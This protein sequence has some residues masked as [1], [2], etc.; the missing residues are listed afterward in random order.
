[1]TAPVAVRPSTPFVTETAIGESTPNLRRVWTEYRERDT[2]L[3]RGMDVRELLSR[4]NTASDEAREPNWNGEDG[5]PVEPSTIDQAWLFAA[6]LPTTLPIPD[7]SPDADGDL[8]FDWN[9]G[10]RRVFSVSVRRD[11]SLSYAALVGASRSHGTG[12]LRGGLP[13]EIIQW[14]QRVVGP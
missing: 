4:I 1:M 5:H 10:P 8:A 12:T 2:S 11:G 14:V 3:L 6:C 9:L 13:P 7:V